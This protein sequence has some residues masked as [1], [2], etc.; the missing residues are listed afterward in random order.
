MLE[1]GVPEKATYTLRGFDAAPQVYDLISSRQLNVHEK[2][3]EYRFT[4]QIPGASGAIFAIYPAGE[5]PELKLSCRNNTLTVHTGFKSGLQP[6]KIMIYLPD[7][8]VQDRSGY[9]T[10]EKGVLKLDLAPALNEPEGEWAV[11][12]FDL[13]TGR[14][15][16]GKITVKRK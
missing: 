6:L 10:A 2:N 12:V 3:G 15:L 9:H 8:S 14:E 4:C 7:G 5:T 16:S 1:K 13:T 11:E